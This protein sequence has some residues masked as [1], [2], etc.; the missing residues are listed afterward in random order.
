MGGY[1]DVLSDV[2]GRGKGGVGWGLI[3]LRG[4]EGG[5]GVREVGWDQGKGRRKILCIGGG[6]GAEMVALASL[7][8]STP[9]ME[10]HSESHSE[11]SGK[12]GITEGFDITIID[13]APWSS[14]LQTLHTAITTPPPLSLY[15]SAAARAKNVALVQPEELMWRFV[16]RDILDLRAQELRSML[17]GKGLGVGEGGEGEGEGEGEGVGLVTLMFTLN[18]LYNS[19]I[20]KTTR[21]LLELGEEGGVVRKGGLLLVVDS[22]G[23]YSMVGGLGGVDDDGAG[24]EGGGG[25]EGREGK[26]YPM[27]W[28]L[29]HTL[30]DS[31]SSGGGEGGGGRKWEKLREEDS[32]WFRWGEEVRYPIKLEDMRMQVHLYRRL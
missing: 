17:L 11:A 30:L 12:H 25:R 10:S 4:E 18:E 2:L 24:R 16:Q 14:L 15:A 7:L 1:A 3:G 6:G 26:K 13:I 27:K 22:A 8:R 19:S 20:A 28:L 29:D 5:M 32:R 9:N 23:S 31:A 21:L